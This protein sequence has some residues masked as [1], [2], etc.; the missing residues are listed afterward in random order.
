MTTTAN[1]PALLAPTLTYPS[2]LPETELI[3]RRMS[4][5]LAISLGDYCQPALKSFSAPAN[6]ASKSLSIAFFVRIEARSD[7]FR[8]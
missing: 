1:K 4:C 2:A 6:S 8:V 3:R 7:S 5:V